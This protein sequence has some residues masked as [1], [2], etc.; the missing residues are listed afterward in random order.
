MRKALSMLANLGTVTAFRQIE[1]YSKSPD[2]ELLQWTHL[3]L[4]ECRM[5]LE[6]SLDEENTGFIMSGLGGEDKRLRFYFLVLP[7]IDHSFTAIHKDIIRDEFAIICREFNS[8]IE[9]IYYSDKY[10]GFTMLMPLDV[11]L[12]TIIDTGIKKCNELGAFVFEYYYATN[13]NI[14]NETEIIDI[15]RIVTED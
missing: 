7:L 4:Q 10:V 3:S 2:K 1:K 5:L 15:I 11:A 9:K 12:G 14:P 8:I 13:Q 6:S